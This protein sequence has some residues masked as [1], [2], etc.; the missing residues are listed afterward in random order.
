MFPLI[1]I[2]KHSEIQPFLIV[3]SSQYML[4][5]NNCNVGESGMYELISSA[6]TSQN[7]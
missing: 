5:L 3:L 7:I 6:D 2:I 1:Y 4:N